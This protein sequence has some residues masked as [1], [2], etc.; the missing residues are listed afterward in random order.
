MPGLKLISLIVLEIT[1]GNGAIIFLTSVTVTSKIAT[2]KS[3]HLTHEN[4]CNKYE[5]DR[6]KSISCKYYCTC[7]YL[8]LRVL[9]MSL[10]RRTSSFVLSCVALCHVVS[11]RV[12]SC[13]V[14][15]YWGMTHDLSDFSDHEIEDGQLKIDRFRSQPHSFAM[16][17]LKLI[18]LT[19]LK[20][21]WNCHLE[22]QGGHL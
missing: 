12:V 11:C 20:V 7:I 14:K 9:T 3:I 2:W 18:G 6:L 1:S 8:H 13:R 19:V 22:I 4:I 17:G 21:P 16:P 10:W 5:V 15:L